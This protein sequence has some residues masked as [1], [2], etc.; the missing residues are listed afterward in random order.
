MKI[1]IL[2]CFGGELPGH[3]PVTFLIDDSIL[4]DAGS[5]L[6]NLEAKR[7]LHIEHIIISHAHVDHIKDLGLL[8]DAIGTSPRKSPLFLHCTDYTKNALLKHYFNNVVWPDF[9]KIKINS[10]NVIEFCQQKIGTPLK[11]AKYSFLPIKMNHTVQTVGH[12]IETQDIR[13]AITSDTT[14]NDNFWEHINSLKRLKVLF[15]ELSFPSRHTDLAIKSGHYSVDI[16]DK[17]LNKLTK[18]DVKIYLYHL[19]PWFKDEIIKDVEILKTHH[20][21]L[22][23]NFL[24]QGS[25][26][27]L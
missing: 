4:Y 3:R 10:K 12:I 22:D 25:I 18:R 24:E 17:E 19:K 14:Y 8:A 13:L 20:R 21:D 27:N 16:L 2:G 23:I 15:V 1:E 6:T 11:I 9:S 26:I 7:L 5:V